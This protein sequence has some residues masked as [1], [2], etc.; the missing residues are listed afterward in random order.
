MPVVE[1]EQQ[2]FVPPTDALTDK[3]SRMIGTLIT[4]G[5]KDEWVTV[6]ELRA[7]TDAEFGK[8]SR[9]ALTKKEASAVIEW[10]LAKDP[11]HE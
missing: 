10:L 3:Q 4:R 1:S 11:S 6:E 5:Q 7:Y 2:E 8:T 9:K